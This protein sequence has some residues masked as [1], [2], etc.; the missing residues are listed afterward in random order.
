MALR[1]LDGIHGLQRRDVI[2]WRV[3]SQGRR[4]GEVGRGQGK[5]DLGQ[6]KDMNMGSSRTEQGTSGKTAATV[7][8]I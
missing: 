4:S 2:W 3:S 8:V 6:G 5:A 1:Y 7:T